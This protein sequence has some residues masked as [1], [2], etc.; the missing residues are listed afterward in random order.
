M[1]TLDFLYHLDRFGLRLTT[2]RLVSGCVDEREI[3]GFLW[4]TLLDSDDVLVCV[5][6]CLCLDCGR[7]NIRS[8]RPV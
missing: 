8:F 6:F 2:L 1:G 5:R 7:I 4:F 3:V